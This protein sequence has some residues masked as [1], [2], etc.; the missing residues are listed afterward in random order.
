MARSTKAIDAKFYDRFFSSIGAFFFK[1]EDENCARTWTSA[2]GIGVK[3]RVRV[4]VGLVGA[5]PFRSEK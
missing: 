4:R 5:I 1:S 2:L 3:V